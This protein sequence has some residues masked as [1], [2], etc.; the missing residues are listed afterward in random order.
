MVE[1]TLSNAGHLDESD[2]EISE[3]KGRGN[4]LCYRR[5]AHATQ[6]GRLSEQ[7]T[8]L[9]GKCLVWLQTTETGDR[10]ELG[11][12]RQ[13]PAFGRLSAQGAADCPPGTGSVFS[14]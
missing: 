6:S 1:E 5:W 10:S 4:Y 9:V 8:S 13:T 3:L 7:E 2:L 14:A 11:L 12:G